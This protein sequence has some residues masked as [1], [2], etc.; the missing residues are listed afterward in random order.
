LIGK[1]AAY[2]VYYIMK[3][4]SV[5]LKG[6]ILI[7]GVLAIA[8]DVLLYNSCE[9]Q[10]M[11]TEIIK[12]Q[13]QLETQAND[14]KSKY[15]QEQIERI[16]KNLENLE[17]Q[18]KDQGESLIAQKDDL[19]AQKDALLQEVEKRQQVENENKSVQIS[20][21]DIKAEADALKQNIKGWQKD[22]VTVLAELEKKMD[23]SQ[24]EITSVK[25][26]L[27]SLN[28]PELEKSINSL[29]TDIEKITHSPDNSLPNTPSASDKKIESLQ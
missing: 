15:Q 16:T 9:K 8:F 17:Q 23:D 28:I 4:L 11:E 7:I 1:W 12:K 2:R 18:I 25:N 10:K 5:L 26:N 19:T 6:L 13:Q 3:F 20:L 29:K 21:V 22:Y 14:N 24:A 27:E